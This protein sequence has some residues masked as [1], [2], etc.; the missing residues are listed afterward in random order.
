MCVMLWQVTHVRPALEMGES[1]DGFRPVKTSSISRKSLWRFWSLA[2]FLLNSGLRVGSSKEPLKNGTVSWQPAHQRDARV[3]TR[4]RV[5]LTLN[6]YA[7]LAKELMRC[8]ECRW[9]L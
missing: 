9:L 3:P 1:F 2:L 5:S 8:A 6:R 4:S 7:G